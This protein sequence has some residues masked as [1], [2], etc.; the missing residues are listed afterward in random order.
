VQPNTSFIAKEESFIRYLAAEER[1]K[2]TGESH[3]DVSHIL[4]LSANLN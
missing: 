3:T 4:D 1:Q 2:E